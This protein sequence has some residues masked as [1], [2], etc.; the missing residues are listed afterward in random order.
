VR[1]REAPALHL[2]HLFLK[3]ARLLKALSVR[4]PW[5]WF[6]VHRAK[7]I[8]NRDW[9]DNNPGLRFRGP[10]LI[11]AS[12]WWQQDEAEEEFEFCME[13]VRRHGI[14]LADEP[15][16]AAIKAQRGGIVGQAT[17]TAAVPHHASPW[18]FGKWGL[19]LAEQK[20]LPFQACKGA[21]GFFNPPLPAEPAV[22]S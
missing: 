1:E 3:E 8:E 13:T 11:H 12:S 6:I 10:V 14:H 16:L 19:V 5:A 18:F 22:A 2:R 9:R 21:L 17:I 20:V 4:Q 15:T 7:D